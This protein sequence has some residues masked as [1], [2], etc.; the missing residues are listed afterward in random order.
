VLQGASFGKYA[1]PL[2]KNG[3][4]LDDLFAASAS[5]KAPYEINRGKTQETLRN[6]RPPLSLKGTVYFLKAPV[7]LQLPNMTSSAPTTAKAP[8]SFLKE[9]VKRSFG[10]KTS[11]LQSC[12]VIVAA[13]SATYIFRRQYFINRATAK[14][15]ESEEIQVR[16]HTTCPL[17]IHVMGCFV[18]FDA[19]HRLIPIRLTDHR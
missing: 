13:A 16:E 7:V 11:A 9:I 4:P 19:K 12:G 5:S 18:P 15:L 8:L 2:L 10:D 17:E 6:T 3:D 14:Q 1:Y